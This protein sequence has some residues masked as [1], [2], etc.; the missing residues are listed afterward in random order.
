MSITFHVQ[1]AKKTLVGELDDVTFTWSA[2][3]D[4]TEI[5]E[6]TSRGEN[7]VDS[8]DHFYH[9]RQLLDALLN[10]EHWRIGEV[11]QS[12][13]IHTGGMTL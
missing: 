5:F 2:S 3:I 8:N 4:P 6:A 10:V 12:L 7:F 13:E 11:G 1:D 9:G